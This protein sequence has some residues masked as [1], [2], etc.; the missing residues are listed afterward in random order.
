ML[1]LILNKHFTFSA[2]ESEKDCQKVYPRLE[3]PATNST[4]IYGIFA[5]VLVSLFKKTYK[6][7]K[8]QQN[9]PFPWFLPCLSV[10]EDSLCANWYEFG[11][12]GSCGCQWH[13][14]WK[15]STNVFLLWRVPWP[16]RELPNN[17]C[18]LLHFRKGRH[19]EGWSARPQGPEWLFPNKEGDR[20]TA[21][22]ERALPV[23][24]FRE[25]NRVKCEFGWLSSVW[26]T[27]SQ[28]SQM[29]FV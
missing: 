6:K 26:Q 9:L 15:R 8:W 24:A 13:G 12:L 16:G 14:K 7:M 27:Q 23:G 19:D 5:Q 11:V 20:G 17:L 4:N 29:G 3:S 1:D 10:L 25:T 18:P 21:A 22:S 2:Q 28:M